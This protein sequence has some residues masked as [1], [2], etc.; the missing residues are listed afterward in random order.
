MEQT[1]VYLFYYFNFERNYDVLNAKSPYFLLTKYI[2]LI[3]TKR[4]RQWKISRTVLEKRNLCFSSYENRKL[5]VKL[6][7]VETP[8]RKKRACFVL[9]ILPERNLLNICVLSQY[10]LYWIKFSGLRLN[11]ELRRVESNGLWRHIWRV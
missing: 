6:W 9:H 8:K 11:G 5:K 10:I 1:C 4:N 7:W 3:K 2:T